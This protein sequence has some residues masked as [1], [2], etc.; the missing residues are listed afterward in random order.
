MTQVGPIRFSP[1][2]FAGAIGKGPVCLSWGLMATHWMPYGKRLTNNEAETEKAGG[3]RERER[4]RV[5]ERERER[6]RAVRDSG[7]A[8]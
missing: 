8:Y 1:G 5:S 3:E 6:A 7:L 2:I 4:E